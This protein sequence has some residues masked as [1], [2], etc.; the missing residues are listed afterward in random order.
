MSNQ[1]QNSADIIQVKIYLDAVRE[2]L[3]SNKAA[4]MSKQFV[5]WE[6]GFKP[7]KGKANIVNTN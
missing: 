5:L 1:E 2:Y 3:N 4:N 6:K 7:L